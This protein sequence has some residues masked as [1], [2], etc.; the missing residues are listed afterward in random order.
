VKRGY[1][2]LLYTELFALVTMA[3]RIKPDNQNLYHY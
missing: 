1:R 2:S 3:A